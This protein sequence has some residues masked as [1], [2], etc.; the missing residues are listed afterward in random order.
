[1]LEKTLKVSGLAVFQTNKIKLIKGQ[2]FVDFI[3]TI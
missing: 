2:S 1:V 3:D